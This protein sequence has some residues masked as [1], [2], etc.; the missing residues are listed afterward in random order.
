MT[1]LR[2]GNSTPRDS[3]PPAC[4]NHLTGL[5]TCKLALADVP[6]CF[7][8]CRGLRCTLPSRLLRESPAQLLDNKYR[9]P[10]EHAAYHPLESVGPRTGC[11]R[12]KLNDICAAAPKAHTL[13]PGPDALH[14]REAINAQHTTAS[15]A[16]AAKGRPRKRDRE[17]TRN[18]SRSRVP[19]TVCGTVEVSRLWGL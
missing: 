7:N 17:S 10:G 1:C 5:A 8:R 9:N 12:S 3:F 16:K 15:L 2:Q 13:D 6:N 4:T 18:R 14:R 19:Q 11:C